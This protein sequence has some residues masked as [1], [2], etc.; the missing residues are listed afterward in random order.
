MF[1]LSNLTI[2][3]FE[4]TRSARASAKTFLSMSSKSAL[5]F[6]SPLS[7]L[8]ISTFEE[9]RSARASANNFLNASSASASCFERYTDAKRDKSS[10]ANLIQ[11]YILLTQK[12]G[13]R[14]GSLKSTKTRTNFSGALD[15]VII[16]VLLGRGVRRPFSI[17]QPAQDLR[18]PKKTI[19]SDFAG[20]LNNGSGLLIGRT[21]HFLERDLFF[22]KVRR[23]NRIFHHLQ[24]HSYFRRAPC[25]VA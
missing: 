6:K 20:S 23:R 10:F 24:N 22:G 7:D 19:R 8:T 14:L 1:P 5:C 17:E 12:D 2:S 9:N 11:H 21:F 3:T 4:G 15:L 13:V 18:V 25:T 16:I